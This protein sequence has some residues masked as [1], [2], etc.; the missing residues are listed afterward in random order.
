MQSEALV[1]KYIP[2]LIIL[3]EILS[4]NFGVNMLKNIEK[5]PLDLD[6]SL[7]S[8]YRKILFVLCN[9]KP[10]TAQMT[11]NLYFIRKRSM[12]YI[13]GQIF[14]EYVFDVSDDK[15]NK[16]NTFVCYSFRN[17]RFDYDLKLLLAKK[18]ITYLNTKMSINII[19]DYEYSIRPCAFKNLWHLIN[20]DNVAFERDK[21]YEIL[22]RIIKKSRKSLLDLVDD[23]NS[24]NATDGDYAEF[25][26]F[27]KN[28]INEN[29]PGTKLIRFLLLDMRN[30]VINA[31]RYE[32]YGSESL[33]ND[34]FDGTRIRLASKSFE[35]MPFAP[36]EA[37]PSL[38]TL[39]ELYDAS[40]CADEIL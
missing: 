18:K 30:N 29:R 22:M 34:Q 10:E 37:K 14:Y 4:R 35:L 36:K 11:R 25:I 31:Q 26:K 12:K 40:N 17:I 19:F 28:F 8:F 3:K 27:I 1:L 5:Y 13:D 33:Y 38:T 6:Q 15:R 32:P 7:V 24:W 16:F 2:Q 21:E 20:N 9:S 23:K 39:M